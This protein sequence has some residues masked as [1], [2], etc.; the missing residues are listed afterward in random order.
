MKILEKELKTKKKLVKAVKIFLIISKIIIKK[1]VFQLDSVIGKR[2]DKFAILTI[3][4][5]EI[6]FQ[7]GFVIEKGCSEIVLDVFYTLQ[8]LIGNSFLDIF[9]VFLC[10]NESE[11]ERM[12]SLEKSF[13]EDDCKVFLH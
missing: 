1:I 13:V 7:F 4:D 2:K 10:D 3:T 12:Y 8:H 11:F 9:Q 5:P 6:N